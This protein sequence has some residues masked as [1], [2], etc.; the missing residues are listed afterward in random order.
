MYYPI[1]VPYILNNSFSQHIQYTE[2]V[3]TALQDFVIC[4]WE[5]T[6]IYPEK[7]AIQNV[8]AADGCIDLVVGYEDGYIGFGGMSKTNFHHIVQTPT[9][10]FGARLKPGAFGQ[11]TGLPATEAMDKFIPLKKIDPAFDTDSFFTLSF[12]QAKE[13]IKGYLYQLVRHKEPNPFVQMFDKLSLSP[14]P[15]ATDLYQVLRFSPRQ[16]QR[17]FMKHFGITPQMA[18]SI[19]RFQRCLDI[20]TSSKVKPRDILEDTNY[21]DQSH[22]IKDFKRNIGL[23][24]FEYLDKHKKMTQIYNTAPA[25]SDTIEPQ[26]TKPGGI[27]M[28]L[29]KISIRILVRK[30]YGTCFDFYKDKLG[31]VPT[32]GDRNGP[33]TSFAAKEGEPACLAIFAGKN[34]E[35]FKGYKQPI[36]N[37][38]PD[39]IVAVIPSNDVDGDYKRLKEAGVE[40][41]GEQTMEDWGMRCAYFRD[42][43][44]NLFEINNGTGI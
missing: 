18:L 19:L 13:H 36:E 23:T 27:T 33:Y 30:D 20:L 14:P 15:T 5:M 12:K 43:E 29:N 42:T 9:K 44:G 34:T 16:C 3:V 17:L 28:E 8:I 32:W 7:K 31:M 40:F 39:T 26:T 1:Q 4:I 22:F 21:Y 2:E 25:L 41:L 24:P 6:P 38:Q 37:I 11:L 35:M 10:F